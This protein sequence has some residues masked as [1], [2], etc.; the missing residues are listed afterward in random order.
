MDWTQRKPCFVTTSPGLPPYLAEELKALGFEAT[1][2]ATGVETAAS[3]AETMG[4]NLRLRTALNVLFQVGDFRCGS[5]DDLY[6]QTLA[7][8]WDEMI[9]P[10]EY[11]SVV[12]RVD[13]PSV[14]NSMY[15]SLK[16]KDAVVDQIAQRRGRRPNAGSQRDAVVLNL[17]WVGPRARL[18]LNTSGRKL[19]DRGYRRIP[20]K[21]PLRETLAAGIL[22]A[23]GY[24]ASKPLVS[25]MCGSG[26]FAIEAAL[27]AQNRAP[28]LLRADFGLTHLMDFDRTAWEALRKAAHREATRHRPAPIIATDIDPKAVDAARKNAVTAGVDHL[29]EFKVCDFADTPVPP[30][31]GVLV[32][33][34]EYG[35]RVGD[36]RELGAT[37]KRLGDFFKQRCPGYTAYL[38]TGARE[39][40]KQVGLRPRRRIPMQNAR[41]ECRLLEYELYEGTRKGRPRNSA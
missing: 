13:T 22:M 9:S 25:P 38:F 5:P 7:L 12:S 20:H 29:I 31:P 24:D 30:G 2:R 36:R 23:A 21:A 26:T 15:P 35:E 34:P 4:L 33:N 28:G 39:L 10:D 17:H 16:V 14:N 18:Y 8:D 27:M 32:V 19:S 6:A 3:L 1:A 40:E 37:Y 11:L 41:I